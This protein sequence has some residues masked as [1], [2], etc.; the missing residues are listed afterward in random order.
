MCRRSSLLFPFPSLASELA[1]GALPKY[2]RSL[3][4]GTARIGDP[5][6]ARLPRPD[7]G[8]DWLGKQRLTLPSPPQPPTLWPPHT[9][10][11]PLHLPGCLQPRSLHH[12]IQR[13]S[14]ATTPSRHLRLAVT[15]LAVRNPDR[16]KFATTTL[17]ISI[18]CITHFTPTLPFP[19]RI[20]H[21]ATSRS[22]SSLSQCF[23]AS[24]STSLTQPRSLCKITV[25]S[26]T[27]TGMLSLC[28]EVRTTNTLPQVAFVIPTAVVAS[29]C[30]V[31]NGGIA[32]SAFRE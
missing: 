29:S 24:A 23:N 9:Y 30:Y 4:K 16:T 26:S 5:S 2:C 21:P 11:S 27:T 28:H 18:S 10:P 32:A 13:F 3:G 14:G 31:A 20:N 1:V 25:G 12:Y 6:R 17:V 15:S 8:G 7:A 22:I 19:L